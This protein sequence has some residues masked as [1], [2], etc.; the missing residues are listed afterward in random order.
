M[1]RRLIVLATAAMF[2]SGPS[3]AAEAVKIGMITTL[4]GGGSALGIDIRD[5][6]ELAIKQEGGTLGGFLGD[7]FRGFLGDRFRFGWCGAFLG[8]APAAA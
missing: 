3:L 1:N 2:L 6:F 8:A 7:R 4:S 5:G